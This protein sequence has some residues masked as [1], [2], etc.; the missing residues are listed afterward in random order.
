MI[1]TSPRAPVVPSTPPSEP[2]LS[3]APSR[4]GQAVLDGG[5][6]PRST[7]PVAELPGLVV[8]LTARHGRIR[9]L[10]LSSGSWDSSFRRLAVGDDV[11]RLGWFATL[12]P[13]LLIATNDHGDQ[14]DLLVVPP[15]TASATAGKAMAAAADPADV[16]HAAEILRDGDPAA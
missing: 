7:D 14:L 3:L 5:W 16:R 2:R 11:V 15:G 9:Q 10:M 8:A 6:W 1:A 4:A 13:A 12:D